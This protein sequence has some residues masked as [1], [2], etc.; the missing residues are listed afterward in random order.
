MRS[1]DGKVDRVHV[2][3]VTHDALRALVDFMYKGQIEITEENAADILVAADLLL[4]ERLKDTICK[5]MQTIICAAN[6]V[7]ISRL[8]D[9]Y[10]CR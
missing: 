3:G 10:S 5:F 6:C 4:M 1:S 7:F 8:A 2:G 9:I